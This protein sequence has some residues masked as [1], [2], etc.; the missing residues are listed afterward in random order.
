MKL[1]GMLATG[2][3]SWRTQ[4][5]SGAEQ[6]AQRGG[7]LALVVIC[8]GVT[9]VVTRLDEAVSCVHA[10]SGAATATACEP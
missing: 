4:V 6:R 2:Q 10:A 1:V 3:E 9:A 7:A 8:G 5:P